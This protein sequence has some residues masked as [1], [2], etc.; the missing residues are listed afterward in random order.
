M[1]AGSIDTTFTPRG[2][3][4]RVWAERTTTAVG[5]FPSYGFFR[6]VATAR[7]HF[8]VNTTP[9]S[10]STVVGR[11]RGQRVRRMLLSMILSAAVAV[12]S[13]A[14]VAAAQNADDIADVVDFAGYYVEDG[15]DFDLNRLEA[16]VARADATDRNWYFVSLAEVADL[17]NDF[18]AEEVQEALPNSGTVIVVSPDGDGFYDVGIVSAD[19]D[20]ATI[21]SGFDT[22]VDLLPP[23]GNATDRLEAMFTG[24]NAED[25]IESG[26]SDGGGSSLLVPV[27]VGGAL[28]GG[29]V[30]WS[31]RRKKK[32]LETK[33][34]GD[35]AGARAEIKAQRDAVAN[36][37][38]EQGDRI[39]ASENAKAIEYYRAATA[40]FA[41]V[42][43][44]L[45]RTDDL[46]GLAE[47]NDRIDYARWQMEAAEALVEGRDVPPE[48]EP[49]KPSACFFDPTHKPG[50][51]VAV[52]HTAAGDKEVNVCAMDAEK[53]R[54][55]QKPTPRMIDVHG[56]RVPSARAP[57][58]HG[59]LGYGGID[60][61]DIVLGGLGS[62]IP[63]RSPRRGGYPGRTGGGMF[64]WT[65]P[66]Q[67]P[68]R[69][70]RARP[71][72]GSVFGPDRVP[73]SRPTSSRPR[74][75]S[76]RRPSSG[77]SRSR[78]SSGGKRSSSG[79]GRRRM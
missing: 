60:I 69:A 59:G 14:P 75:T 55:G 78:R 58:S 44:L 22:A 57:R 20:D 51:E 4:A 3:M 74:R 37:V 23:D 32:Q 29:G 28:L 36:Y 79:R 68:R 12:L 54:Q 16:L 31:N 40:T 18:F 6:V 48:P 50:T 65:V 21:S 34:A 13:L 27:L 10:P 43:D 8:N 17:G 24:L 42:D 15:A 45:P 67:Q 38:I 33:D 9:I 76:T 26:G 66:T 71:N 5:N 46:M 1:A 63:R 53:L 47:L 2:L 64:D 41:E 35:V 25:A 11:R 56:R 77:R 62:G 73:R 52:V 39:D 30:M 19:Y 61:F 7:Y 70:P 49:D 72:P